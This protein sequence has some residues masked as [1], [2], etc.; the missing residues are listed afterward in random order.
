MVIRPHDSMI[1]FNST[2]IKTNNKYNLEPSSSS[3]KR[4]PWCYNGISLLISDKQEPN[5]VRKT[6]QLDS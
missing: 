4:I 3:G 5:I 1:C 6:I 2:I